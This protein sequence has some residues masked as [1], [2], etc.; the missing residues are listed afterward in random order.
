MSLRDTAKGYSWLTIVFH[1]VTAITVI[2]LYILGDMAEDAAQVERRLLL[3]LHKSI[4]ISMYIILWARIGWRIG[5]VRPEM[6][7]Q[8]RALMFLSRWVPAVLLLS[9]ALLLISGPL[10]VWSNDRPLPVF[11]LFSIPSPLGK[12]ESLHEA[13]EL[14]HKFSAR[15][16]FYAFLLH[17]AGA[18]KHLLFDRDNTLMRMIK[19]GN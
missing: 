9:L 18:A 14:L 5:N 19:A 1:W 4:A 15:I 11:S 10:L 17:F 6:P 12:I 2:A 8:H 3:D 7:E 16:I 13:M